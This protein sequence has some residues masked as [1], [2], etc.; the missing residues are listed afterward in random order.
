[1]IKL[2]IHQGY[3]ENG[4]IVNFLDVD[5][6]TRSKSNLLVEG[7]A[8]YSEDPST[9]ILMTSFYD[10]DSKRVRNS[11]QYT[12][13]RKNARLLK[14]RFEQVAADP[15]TF[16]VRAQNAEFEYWNYINVGMKQNDWPWLPMSAFFCTTTISCSNSYPA[17]LEHA[18][19][20]MDLP[21]KKDE[22]G[23]GLITWFSK[24]SAKQCE[25]FRDP[26]DHPVKFQMF[27]D[28]C[29]DDVRV[30]MGI[31]KH[32]HPLSPQQIKVAKITDQMNVHGLPIDKDMCLGA[33]KLMEMYKVKANARLEELTGGVIKKGTQ[34]TALCKF[35]NKKYRA[36]MPNMTS[37]TVAAKLLEEDLDLVIRECLEIRA[38]VSMTSLAKYS[39]ALDQLT[40]G[41]TVHGFIK[42][43][44]AITGRWKGYGIQIQNFSKPDPKLFPWWDSYDIEYLCELITKADYDAIEQVFGPVMEVLKAA[45]R[46]IIKAPKG[47]KFIC[48]DYAQIE[49]RIV[50]WMADDPVGLAD[51][52]GDGKIYEKMAAQIFGIPFEDILKGSF[53]RDVGKEDVLGSG[54]GMG[55]KKFQ[56]Q[57][58]TKGI[59]ITAELAKRC[60]EYYRKRYKQV[61]RAWYDCEDAAKMAIQN[62]GKKFY[63]CKNKLCYEYV[64]NALRVRMPSGRFIYYPE[65]CLKTGKWDSLEIHY[66]NWVNARHVGKEWDWQS[67]WGGTLFQMTVQGT[68]GDVMGQGLLNAD[69]AG[70]FNLFA[71]HDEGVALVK[72]NFGSVQEYERLLCKQKRWAKGIPLIAEGW[73]GPRYK[74]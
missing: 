32:C 30:Q 66:K 39:S 48:A 68:A 36:K 57:C 17:K 31:V 67:I 33:L 46:A 73:E 54:F 53:E 49:A 29:D 51:F 61:K 71:V 62:K 41:G 8:K 55:W 24:P 4:S 5:F 25:E 45:T 21:T 20:A 72:N 10:W 69:M 58:L 35:L 38:Y 63:A 44:H 15:V 60:I 65:A 56:S 70:Y 6:E 43:F 28:Y 7:A 26:L 2:P 37:P 18:G 3:D 16:K 27:V 34:A 11:N 13:T 74:K 52:A 64:G 14:S 23:K 47:Y 42:A 19:Q 12:G 9:E 50:M 40:E 22:K 59:K 1:M